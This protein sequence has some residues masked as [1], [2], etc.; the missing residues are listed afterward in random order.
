MDWKHLKQLLIKLCW[1]KAIWHVKKLDMQFQPVWA[2]SWP[3][4]FAYNQTF[5]QTAGPHRSGGLCVRFHATVEN[6]F[7][8]LHS[9]SVQ[10][11]KF[12]R[13]FPFQKTFVNQRPN[14]FKILCTPVE[15]PYSKD[16]L[17]NKS[18]TYFNAKTSTTA[19]HTTTTR[20]ICPLKLLEQTPM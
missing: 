11:T 17:R 14:V 6:F 4:W 12:G 9:I 8:I 10:R 3:F 2:V 16:R 15:P 19:S 20:T 1:L 18:R 13:R 5:S 7:H